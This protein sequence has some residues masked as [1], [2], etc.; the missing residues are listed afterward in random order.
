MNIQYRSMQYRSIFF[1][2]LLLLFC[3]R[4]D[5]QDNNEK[6]GINELIPMKNCLPKS[7]NNQSF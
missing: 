1:G 4:N 3:T 7:I 5:D 2:L 6:P